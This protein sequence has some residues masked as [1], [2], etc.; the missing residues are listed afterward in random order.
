MPPS[1]RSKSIARCQA[2]E[3]GNPK[4]TLIGSRD[5]GIE[6]VRHEGYGGWTAER[7]ATKYSGVARGGPYRDNGSPFLYRH[8]DPDGLMLAGQGDQDESAPASLDFGRYCKVFNHDQ[9]PDFVTLLLGCNDTFHGTDTDI[10]DR[11][12]NMFAHY[13][14]TVE[15]DSRAQPRHPDRRPTAG[16]SRRHAGRLRRQLQERSDPLAVQAQPAPRRRAHD[17]DLRRPRGQGTF[18]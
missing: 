4:L 9:A 8:G 10:E 14:D 11:I 6:G 7:F 3:I 12:D 17:R 1:T 13:E 16:P 18:S 5:P 15:D 2:T